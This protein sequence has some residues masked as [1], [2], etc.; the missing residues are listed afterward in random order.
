VGS[1]GRVFPTDMKAAPLLRAWL[2]RLRESGVKICVRHRW[3]GWSDTGALMFDSPNGTQYI[4]ADAVILACGGAS[5]PRLGSN[6]AWQCPCYNNKALPYYHYKRL[7]VVL[8]ATGQ[9]SLAKNLQ[10]SPLNR[11]C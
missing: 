9:T 8:I 7:I 5:W 3:L 4:Q 10:G 1:S 6:G 2:H 11:V